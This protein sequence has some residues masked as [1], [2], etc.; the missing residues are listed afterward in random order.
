MPLEGFEEY[1]KRSFCR[2]VRCPTQLELD[3]KTEGSPEY[4]EVK[5]KCKE[6]GAWKFHKWLTERGFLVLRPR[7]ASGQ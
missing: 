3:A 2:D 5:E 1:Q 4:Q 7:E 6:C